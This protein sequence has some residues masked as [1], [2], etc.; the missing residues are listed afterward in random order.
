MLT[1]SDTGTGM[2]AE[3]RER[4]FEPFFTTKANV[5]TGLGLSTVYNSIARWGGS[6]T[7]ESEPGAGTTFILM[8][9]LWTE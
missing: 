2:D 7:V 5:G 8:L 4:V 1:F 6:I 9:S 3:I